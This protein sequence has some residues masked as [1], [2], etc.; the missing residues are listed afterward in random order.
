[1][2]AFCKQTPGAAPMSDKAS[3]SHFQGECA[4]AGPVSDTGS[5]SVIT[6]L[7]KDEKCCSTV[8]RREG[9]VYMRGTTAQ[10]LRSVKKGKSPPCTGADIL[11]Q[12]IEQISHS[13]WRTSCKMCPGVPWRKLQ[14]VNRSPYRSSF[15]D[16]TCA[17]TTNLH[18]N[19]LTEGT[20]AIAV[21]ED[22]SP[23]EGLMLEKFVKDCLPWETPHAGGGK[24]LE[25][26]GAANTKHEELMATPLLQYSALLRGS[27]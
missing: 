27:R 26:E 5:T 3:S 14:P 8:A 7:R 1:M 16:R 19:S 22:L 6:N 10:I 2:A 23:Q 18:W 9:C 20:H 11:L 21:L 17:A 12:P 15:S 25:E 24:D 13:L 4:K